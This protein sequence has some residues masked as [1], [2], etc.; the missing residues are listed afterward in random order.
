MR[1][2]WW[3]LPVWRRCWCSES[4]QNYSSL[5]KVLGTAIL[6]VLIRCCIPKDVSSM[7]NQFMLLI[8]ISILCSDTIDTKF[9]PN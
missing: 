7:L 6:S 2:Y 5:V 1:F 9:N 3:R 4:H 8:F